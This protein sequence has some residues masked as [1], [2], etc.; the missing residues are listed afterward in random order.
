MSTEI[1]Y[2]QVCSLIIRDY[3]KGRKTHFERAIEAWC[4]EY[5]SS[6]E[7]VVVGSAERQPNSSFLN[8]LAMMDHLTADR[9]FFKYATINQVSSLVKNMTDLLVQGRRR[10]NR[11]ILATKGVPDYFLDFYCDN[12]SSE[13]KAIRLD[14]QTAVKKDQKYILR[15]T[16]RLI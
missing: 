3:T 15:K 11:E 9:E 6:F 14:L 12:G 13:T 4:E 2:D 10:L 16:S 7:S 5:G 1:R 8:T